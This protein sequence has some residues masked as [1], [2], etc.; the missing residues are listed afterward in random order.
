MTADPKA[1]ATAATE[2][3]DAGTALRAC[4]L[5]VRAHWLERT[6]ELLLEENNE[7]GRELRERLPE[8]TGLSPQ[9]VRW[10]L[11]TSLQT[12]RQET[13]ERMV[14]EAELV[15]AQLQQPLSLL[16][17]VLAG[18]LFAAALRAMFVPLLFSVPVLAKASSRNSAFAEILGRALRQ[19]DPAL[20]R[21]AQV[22]VFSGGELARE[23]ALLRQAEAVSVY[24]SDETVQAIRER[25]QERIPVIP[26]GHGLSLAYCGK[27]SLSPSEL[28]GTVERL[29]IDVAAYDQRG[30]LSPQWIFI[31][32][33]QSM[34]PETF[35]RAL[36]RRGLEPVSE[37]LPR[38]P[39]PP[40]VGAAQAQWRGVAEAT[41][42]LIVGTEHAV[43]VEVESTRTARFSPGYRNVTVVPVR[44][45]A[46]AIERMRPFSAQ[47]KCI[48]VTDDVLAEL[49]RSAAADP[50]NEA[51]LCEV[52]SMQ[53]PPFDAPADGRPAWEGLLRESV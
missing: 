47:T 31:E 19:V 24:G 26:H 16:A 21:A 10:G 37:T 39:L 2:A 35:A 11:R 3:R 27:A 41:G 20:G 43:A 38:G 22:L 15:G 48:G 14:A 1:I 34:S 4:S 18:N 30:C 36:S 9:M 46:D 53:T 12:V 32:A 7:L 8:E 5:D 17:L 44:G 6:A 50:S 25:L 52:G 13:L 29:A 40:A 45:P 49:G 28:S 51:F 42:R 33:S 23:D